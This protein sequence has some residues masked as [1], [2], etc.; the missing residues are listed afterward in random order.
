MAIK[1]MPAAL[2]YVKCIAFAAV[3]ALPVCTRA[4]ADEPRVKYVAFGWDTLDMSPSELLAHAD[5][6][7]STGIDGVV[8]SLAKDDPKVGKFGFTTFMNDPVWPREAMSEDLAGCRKL[9][10]RPGLKDSFFMIWLQPVKRLDWRDDAAWGRLAANAGT[11]AWFAKESGLK[12]LFIDNEDYRKQD[13]FRVQA[14]DGE[15]DV[16]AGLARRRGAEVGRAIFAEYP[17][18]TVLAFWLFSQVPQYLV[19]PDPLTV[20]RITGDLWPAFLNG[21]MDV[22]PPQ[23]RFIDGNENAYRFRADRG[24]FYASAVRQRNGALRCVAPENRAKYR[25]QF[26]AGF[27]I[28][29]DSYCCDPKSYWYMEP[30][31][32]SRL[33]HFRENLSQATEA[34]DSYVWLYG[35]HR[36][37]VRWKNVR[38]KRFE[39]KKTWEEE[40]PGLAEVLRQV[41]EPASL[42]KVLQTMQDPIAFVDQNFPRNVKK[43]NLFEKTQYVP[44]R[45]KAD[46]TGRIYIDTED[47]DADKSS[48]ATEAFE[49]PACLQF[50]QKVTPGEIYVVSVTAKGEK[51]RAAVRWVRNGAIDWNL[52]SYSLRF[53]DG[54]ADAWRRG[55]TLVCVPDGA[56]EL[57]LTLGCLQGKGS[58]VNYDNVSLYKVK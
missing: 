19:S 40:L 14:V 25:T 17:D 53:E 32:G 44:W 51:A 4:V 24:D 56:D 36:T 49:K 2:W 3:V 33:E 52:A 39:D 26:N 23:A 54:P 35:E 28:Y 15:Y 50:V 41:R 18:I 22:M 9:V 34:A 10:S 48:I 20:A 43:P 1:E 58:R 55:R 12:G 57:K 46:D 16:A 6:L 45:E 30:K 13:Q 29:L 8:V 11:A 38:A 27:G 37:W 42:P 7:A 47:G 31:K 5:A 21:L